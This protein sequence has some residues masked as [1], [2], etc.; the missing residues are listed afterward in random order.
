[1]GRFSRDGRAGAGPPSP[2]GARR[3]CI[4]VRYPP[5]TAAWA[6]ASRAIGTRNGLQET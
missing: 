4:E 5:L 6:A 1:M 2:P 3:R